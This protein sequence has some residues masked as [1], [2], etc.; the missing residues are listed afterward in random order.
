MQNSY[1][2]EGHFCLS[3]GS[4]KNQDDNLTKMERSGSKELKSGK[5]F[6][7]ATR[8]LKFSSIG[9]PL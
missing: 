1:I 7:N 2:V 3:V 8:A 9:D 5:H 4:E 6:S